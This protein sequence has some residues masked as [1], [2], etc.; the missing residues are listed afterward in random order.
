[1]ST[2]NEFGANLRAVRRGK[3]MSQGDLATKADINRSYL[4][5]IENGHSSPTIDVVSRLADALNVNIIVLLST[6][7][8]D[9][10]VVVEASDNER[11]VKY[12]K[13]N[14]LLYQTTDEEESE[15]LV[16]FAKMEPHMGALDDTK[17]DNQMKYNL[18]IIRSR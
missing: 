2:N 16:M 11:A 15:A 3:R 13:T 9:G 12:L 7:D 10:K 14:R 1:M 4:S 17:I 8:E 6:L 5:M 18:E